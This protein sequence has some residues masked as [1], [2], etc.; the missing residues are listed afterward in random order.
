[1][2]LSVILPCLD[3]AEILGESLGE[4]Q[5]LRERGHELV[6]VDG[7]SRDGSVD[8]AASLVDR[9]LVST[10]GRAGQ[11]NLGA[12]AASEEI[13]W[14]MHVDTRVFP[15]ADREIVRALNGRPGWGRFDVR[16]SGTIPTL[17]L[18][19]WSMNLRSRLTGIATGDQGIFVT[20][21]LFKASGGYPEIALMEDIELSRRLKRA[22][23]PRCITRPLET[24]SRRWERQGIYRTIAKMWALR[25]AYYF[26]ADPG[27]LAARYGSSHSS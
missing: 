3:E 25:L 27:H 24:S 20:R 8:V 10:P 14:F 18:V 9:I 23:R 26:G 19:E 22:A 12:R 16:L 2:S 15:G 4:L 5:W 6:L 1:M 21:D 13:L 17:R 7:G 11:M